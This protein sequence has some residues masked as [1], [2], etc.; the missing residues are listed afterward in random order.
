MT[1]YLVI[2]LPKIPFMHRVGQNRIYTV[3]IR[4]FCGIF[5]REITKYTVI[6]G[7]YIRFWPTLNINDGARYRC[8]VLDI[9]GAARAA[10]KRVAHKRRVQKKYMHTQS[11][12]H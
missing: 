8:F 11:H 3:Y 12:V 1:V 2:S 10:H 4:Y 9:A 5:G 6:Y 7:V